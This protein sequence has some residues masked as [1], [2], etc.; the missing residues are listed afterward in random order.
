MEEEI[1][2]EVCGGNDFYKEA[3]FF[4]CKECQTQSQAIKEHCFSEFDPQKPPKN[5]SSR[6][7]NKRKKKSA[8]GEDS[9]TSWECY[10]YILLGLVNEM[11]ELGA[12]KELK[13]IVHVLWY[14]Y[15]KSLEVIRNT[16]GA[17]PKLSAVKI[18]K[19]TQI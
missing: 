19:Y 11:I 13:K 5:C 6:S 15:L 18:K 2:C 1:A 17:L 4:Y 8:K 7:I 14:K 3:G 10:N 12:G 9:M 16:A